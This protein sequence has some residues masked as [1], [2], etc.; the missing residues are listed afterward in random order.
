M[1][2]KLTNHAK[3]KIGQRNIKIDDIRKVALK[4]DLVEPDKYDKSLTHFIGEIGDRFLRI[5]GRW[6]SEEDLLIISAFFDRR[7]KR[8]KG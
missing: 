7:L 8:K 5:I 3:T 4:P 6:K 2:I 1:T